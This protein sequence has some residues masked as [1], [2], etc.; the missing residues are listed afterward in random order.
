MTIPNIYSLITYN[1]QII[2]DNITN[3]PNI[4][5]WKWRRVF[6]NNKLVQYDFFKSVSNVDRWENNITRLYEISK[7]LG[8]KYVVFLQ[9]TMGLNGIQSKAPE[10]TNDFKLLENISESYKYKI[11]DLYKD[12]RVRCLKYSYCFDISN[13]APPLGDYYHDPRHHNAKGNKIIAKEI[14][15]ILNLNELL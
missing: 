2:D 8:A 12:L 4:S 9:P 5:W 3:S 11:N 13:I 15:N 14:L 1:N 7:L 10:G 6:T